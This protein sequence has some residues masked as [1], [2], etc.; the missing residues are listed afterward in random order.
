MKYHFNSLINIIS[1]GKQTICRWHPG[2]NFPGHDLSGGIQSHLV[3]ANKSQNY[4]MYLHS[5]RVN[6]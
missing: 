1:N 4:Q 3:E 5:E 6:S 2:L